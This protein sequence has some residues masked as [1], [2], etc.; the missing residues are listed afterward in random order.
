MKIERLQLEGARSGAQL[1]VPA[2]KG[3]SR[4]PSIDKH[5]ILLLS[6]AAEFRKGFLASAL[7][8]PLDFFDGALPLSYV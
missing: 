4:T 3:S 8:L 2:I 1:G 5:L 7:L 6:R